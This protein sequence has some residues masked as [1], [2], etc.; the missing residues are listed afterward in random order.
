MKRFAL[1]LLGVLLPFWA[2]SATY[3]I[4]CTASSNGAG[5]AYTVPF[6]GVSAT[7]GNDNSNLNWTNIGTGDDDVLFKAGT[8]CNNAKLGGTAG[9]PTGLN[10]AGS[11]GDRI[12]IGV[13][14][15]ANGAEI[16]ACT[17]EQYVTFAGDGATRT[18]MI[19]LFG[20]S[21]WTQRCFHAHGGSWSSGRGQ[22]ALGQ[23]A[24]PVNN[25]RVERFKITQGLSPV[26]KSDS[27][28]ITVGGSGTGT[29]G[30][31]VTIDRADISG[32]RATSGALGVTCSNMNSCGVTNSTIDASTF[33]GGATTRA[34]VLVRSTTDA[35]YLI[36]GSPITGNTFI[37]GTDGILYQPFGATTNYARLIGANWS[38][39]SFLNQTG[40]GIR[41]TL[42][43]Q[44]L[45]NGNEIV[46]AGLAAGAGAG[47]YIYPS[48]ISAA[49]DGMTD[50]DGTIISGN[51]I[52]DSGQFAIWTPGL[53]EL[54]IDD[55]DI[56]GCGFVGSTYSRCIE[57][58]AFTNPLET[59]A[60]TLTLSATTGTGVTATAGSAAFTAA[61]I[62]KIISGP[63][64]N[65]GALRITGYTS[66]TVVTGEV[67]VP[68]AST[69]M[70]AS[71]WS[72]DFLSCENRI[73]NN[74]VSGGVAAFSNG[75][76]TEGLGIG[77]DDLTCKTVVERNY[78]TDNSFSGISVNN[79][80]GNI[81]RYNVLAR[82]GWG[83]DGAVGR[84]L[85]KAQISLTYTGVEVYGN[86]MNCA[87]NPYGIAAENST[88]S[89]P[90]QV[91][92]GGISSYWNNQTLNCSV[93]GIVGNSNDV[94]SHNSFFGNALN[95]V[96]MPQLSFS[97]APTEGN[98]TAQTLDGA[99]LTVAPQL[100][101][102]GNPLTEM[103][104]RPKPGSPL[105]G[106][107]TRVGKQF[108]KSGR[109]I[110][111]PTS[112]GAY[113]CGSGR[114]PIATR[115]AAQSRARR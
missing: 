57:L 85:R 67:L 93:A 69:S 108:D 110:V 36:T 39:N 5:T 80:N 18:E 90:S 58:T 11:V 114:S 91:A 33:G 51:L 103:G 73:S 37:G 49:Q 29:T 89:A 83:S 97:S 35:G 19:S 102:G 17:P 111:P 71:T 107:G 68:F 100:I 109:R 47:I 27:H 54:V 94:A 43:K 12:R 62:D 24:G 2:K 74:R 6:W 28:G 61:D 23:G 106:A 40:H 32:I 44:S 7:N 79:G 66:T 96:W 26:D 3:Y 50:T 53:A 9:F 86:S 63:T 34:S 99:S 105:C 101:G 42:L 77:L 8:T 112:I 21:Y 38:D 48:T 81:I 31:D 64:H 95:Y 76:G 87:G 45:I 10:M 65:G 46:G 13:Y 88:T 84:S 70:V 113:Q 56:D 30:N 78:V 16:D 72:V 60:T 20:V 104:F 82:N 14:D 75:G 41:S 22:V 115:S 4:D 92:H 59:F 98:L 55:N 25:V 52:E 15:P 1:F